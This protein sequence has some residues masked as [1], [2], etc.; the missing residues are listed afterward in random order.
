MRARLFR[1]LL[2]AA[3]LLLTLS[4]NDPTGPLVDDARYDLVHIAGEALPAQAFQTDLVRVTTESETLRF[5]ADGTG[6]DIRSQLVEQP[7]GAT[8]EE[9][10]FDTPFHYVVANGRI[11]IGFDCPPNASCVAPPHMIGRMTS[12]GISFDYV[13]GARTPQEFVLVKLL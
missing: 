1:P 10:H 8:P 12:A 13:L 5:R 3:P 11:Q 4:C 2:A 9:M 7:A 6:S